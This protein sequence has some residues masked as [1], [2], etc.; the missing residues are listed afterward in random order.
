M[1]GNTR[2]NLINQIKHNTTIGSLQVALGASIISFSS[3]FVKWADVSPTVSGFYRMLFGSLAL[4]VLLVVT[5]GH[6]RL[7]RRT[8]LFALLASGFFAMD[9]FCWHYSIHWIGPGLAT[10]LANFQV[11]ILATIGIVIF[12]EV[13]SLRLVTSIL[14]AMLGLVLLIG[15]QWH[16]GT[17]HYQRGIALGLLTACCYAGYV[18]SLRQAQSKHRWQEKLGILLVVTALCATWLGC[19]AASQ[20]HSFVIPNPRSWLALLT[21]GILCQCLA[22]ACISMGLPKIPSSRVG[23]LLLLQPTLAF[24]WDLLFFAQRLTLVQ[25]F[26]AILALM[27]I[28]VGQRSGTQRGS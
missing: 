25:S 24:V 16:T 20:G 14:L 23:L 21:Y 12:R 10:L 11:F 28:Y 13:F 19:L 9:L 15:K 22:W 17:H 3:V 7:T 27:A 4:V 18:L 5:R 6:I 26:G 1:P 8:G 2:S